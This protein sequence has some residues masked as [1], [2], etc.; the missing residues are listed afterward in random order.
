MI[1]LKAGADIDSRTKEAGS[2]PLIMAALEGHKNAVKWLLGHGADTSI[3]DL[4]GGT[5]E[6]VAR[7]NGKG[8][9]AR[10]IARYEKT[11]RSG[12]K[13]GRRGFWDKLLGR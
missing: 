6:E 12:T 5:A 9:I 8:S 4:D 7:D 13:S 3:R 2:T 11:A 1:L 10:L